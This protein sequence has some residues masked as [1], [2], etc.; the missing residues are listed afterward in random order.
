[1]LFF[2]TADKDFVF[3]PSLAL[4]DKND[5]RKVLYRA[6]EPLMS[7]TEEYELHGKVPKVIF[8]SGLVEKDG[9]YFYYYG[10]A[11]KYV[12]VATIKKTELEKYISEI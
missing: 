1:M 2:N 12:A 9:V 4:L 11:D 10:A 8:G 3:H 5:P 6:D 7:P